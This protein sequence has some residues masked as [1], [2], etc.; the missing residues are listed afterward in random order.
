MF[1]MQEKSTKKA[2]SKREIVKRGQGNEVVQRQRWCWNSTGGTWNPLPLGWGEKETPP[3]KRAG[4]RDE[5]VVNTA[6]VPGI[7]RAQDR[8]KRNPRRCRT[9][10]DRYMHVPLKDR[11]EIETP[12]DKL[13]EGVPYMTKS[14]FPGPYITGKD[15]P[16]FRGKPS[17]RYNDLAKILDD[18]C[19]DQEGRRENLIRE[20]LRFMES[21]DA[22]IFSELFSAEE[23]NARRAAKFLTAIMTAAEPHVSRANPDGGKFVRACLRKG[24]EGESFADIIKYFPQAQAQGN[25]KFRDA[26]E[27]D[28]FS[29]ELDL[30]DDSDEEVTEESTMDEMRGRAF[31][32]R[33]AGSTA[34]PP[35]TDIDEILVCP[36]GLVSVDD[37][38]APEELRAIQNEWR[39]LSD[40]YIA[41]YGI[42]GEPVEG[43]AF[44]FIYHGQRCKMP[45][46]SGMMEGSYSWEYHI[47]TIRQRLTDLGA[48]E[49]AFYPGTS[50]GQLFFGYVLV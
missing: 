15:Q 35:E 45:I 20:M 28:G 1:F 34:P 32:P 36:E 21:N 31:V 2:E 33:E 22:I 44:L 37:S 47:D 30:S 42:A 39:R 40:Q 4:K 13:G 3:P 50:I 29:S 41:Q 38:D 12:F 5:E 18:W 25:Q 43:A 10:S 11:T 8:R 17:T 49:I 27:E 6:L 24:L 16:K 48:E 23:E 46:G 9:R 26:M 19:D 7:K 14:L